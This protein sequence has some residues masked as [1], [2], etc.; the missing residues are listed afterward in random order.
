MVVAVGGGEGG[1]AVPQGSVLSVGIRRTSMEVGVGVF[2]YVYTLIAN[3]R[4]LFGCGGHDLW[5]TSICSIR[6][7]LLLWRLLLL[8]WWVGGWGGATF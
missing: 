6:F 5:Q 7:D 4:E 1:I 3:Q 2:M 8:V